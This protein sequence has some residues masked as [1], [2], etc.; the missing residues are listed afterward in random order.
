M[1]ADLVSSATKLLTPELLSRIASALG[2][3]RA[4][5]EKA[6]SAGIPGILAAF[7]S[8]VGRPGGAERLSDAVAQQQPNILTNIANVIGGAGQK[9][10][11][12]SGLGALSSLLGG[13]TLSTLSNAVARYTGI[14]EAGTKSLMGLLGPMLMG[15]LGQQQRASGLDA[16]GLARMLQSQ[17]SSIARALPSGFANYLSGSGILDSVTGAAAKSSA[18]PEA[19]REASQWNWALPVLA[20]LALGAIG[21]YLLTRTPTEPVATLPAPE[22][23]T[24]AQSPGPATF[25]VTADEAKTWIGR[26]VFSSDNKKVGEIM[27]ITRD[28][29]NKVTDVYIDA[30][31]SLGIGATRYHVTSDEVREVRPDSLVLTLTESEANAK[32]QAGDRQQ[33]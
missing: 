20:L 3:D 23:D 22:A 8:L 31:T 28:P 5:I 30:G 21:W 33:Q 18:A 4:A 9:E 13:N 24:S 25:I 19:A 7:L 16:S 11:V 12:D 2:L 1:P 26:P 32:S 17:K 10:L 15:V 29:G 14:G 27:E 6:A